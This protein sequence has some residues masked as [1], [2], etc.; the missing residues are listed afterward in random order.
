MRGNGTVPGGYVATMLLQGCCKNT[1][2][3][4]SLWYT[5]TYVG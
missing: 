2:G 4:A 5:S 3:I 1:M